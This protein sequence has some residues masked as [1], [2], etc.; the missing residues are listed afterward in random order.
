[1]NQAAVS[2]LPSEGSPLMKY[3]PVAAYVALAECVRLG[4]TLSSMEV[5]SP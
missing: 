3:V 5:T 1:M 2:V 4:K